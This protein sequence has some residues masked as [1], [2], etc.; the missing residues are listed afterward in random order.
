M[1]NI[2]QTKLIKINMQTIEMPK[3]YKER[4]DELNV[5]GS[6]LIDA[7]KSRVWSTS[8]SEMHKDTDKRFSLRTDPLTE[9]KRVWRL[10]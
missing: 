8:L 3:T 1:V 9:D 4:L 2:Y 7:A 5:G 10:K 6:I